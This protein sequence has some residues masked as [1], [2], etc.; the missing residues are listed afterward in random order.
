M[1]YILLQMEDNGY[2]EDKH[3]KGEIWTTSF[4][5]RFWQMCPDD[6][7]EK[8]CVRE[9]VEIIKKESSILKVS[10]LMNKWYNYFDK[11]KISDILSS[12]EE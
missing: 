3:L 8:F 10:K 9:K 11:N 7:L 5:P 12:H 1:Y 2:G 4:T 6:S